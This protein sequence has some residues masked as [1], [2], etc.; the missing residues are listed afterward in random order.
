[1]SSKISSNMHWL[2]GMISTP[3]SIWFTLCIQNSYRIVQSPIVLSKGIQGYPRVWEWLNEKNNISNSS[4]TGLLLCMY[5]ASEY[6]F[7]TY[8][9]TADD[10]VLYSDLVHEILNALSLDWVVSSEHVSSEQV[11]WLTPWADS[12][13][14][15]HR[16]WT[17]KSWNDSNKYEECRS[18]VG[19]T[20]AWC[21]IQTMFDCRRFPIFTSIHLI[22]REC[23]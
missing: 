2:Y 8:P 9:S 22:R 14:S 4:P 16:Y 7:F 19:K 17:E 15:I 21:V 20:I 3:I 11:D 13:R 10:I 18:W 6:E 23:S 12:N 5:S 1:M